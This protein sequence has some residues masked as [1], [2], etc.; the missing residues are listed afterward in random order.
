[1]ADDKA[2]TRRETLKLAAA[3]AAF[4]MALGFRPSTPDA[5][6]PERQVK[7]GRTEVKFNRVEVKL[8]DGPQLLHTCAM[9]AGVLLELKKGRKLDVKWYRDNA[10]VMDPQR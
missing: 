8:Y 10:L 7:F 5:G 2:L 9:P 1:M 3:I 6:E 4:G